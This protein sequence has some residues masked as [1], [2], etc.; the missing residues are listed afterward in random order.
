MKN[1]IEPSPKSFSIPKLY[2]KS[3]GK[4]VPYD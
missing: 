1:K 3:S 4:L 2:S